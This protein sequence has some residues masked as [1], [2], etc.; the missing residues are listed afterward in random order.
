MPHPP[1]PRGMRQCP[2]PIPTKEWFSPLAIC[3]QMKRPHRDTLRVAANVYQGSGGKGGDSKRRPQ[4]RSK[5][6]Q[7]KIC[8]A[9]PMADL[10][11][12][13]NLP[14][15]HGERVYQVSPGWFLGASHKGEG[16]KAKKE[17]ERVENRIGRHWS[18]CHRL[19]TG[20]FL[21]VFTG[22]ARDGQVLLKQQHEVSSSIHSCPAAC[23]EF[24]GSWSGALSGIFSR[25][26]TCCH[27][28]GW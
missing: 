9:F 1:V 16:K 15:P 8:S 13:I 12:G 21:S 7:T 18:C 17:K 28:S 22:Q 5:Q 14:G 3:I 25:G 19:K 23:C 24:L 27:S 11:Q 2:Q 10:Q 6:E 20:P 4:D 26:G